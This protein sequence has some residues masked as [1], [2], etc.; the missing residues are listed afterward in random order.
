M[1][2]AWTDE[3]LG[4]DAEGQGRSARDLA[5]NDQAV[6]RFAELVALFFV[7]LVAVGVSY[8]LVTSL[9][10]IILA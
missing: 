3:G 10:Q 2:G 8:W 9:Y 4:H 5:G 6:F 7:A 1:K